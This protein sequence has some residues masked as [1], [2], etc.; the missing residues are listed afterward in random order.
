MPSLS[1]GLGSMAAA[2]PYAVAA[3]FSHPNRPV[4]APAGEGAMQINNVAQLIIVA[5]YW[6]EWLDLRWIV[7]VFNNEDLNHARGIFECPPCVRA[8]IGEASVAVFTYRIAPERS[9]LESRP[10]R[11]TLTAGQRSMPSRQLLYNPLKAAA[12]DLPA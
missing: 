5:K 10:I 3:R 4:I 6:R 2:V 1:G 9:L 11:P 12:S 8:A 7:S